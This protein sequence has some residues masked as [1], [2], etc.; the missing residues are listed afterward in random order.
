M[1]R[2]EHLS[3]RCKDAHSVIRRSIRGW[4][5]KRGLGQIGPGSELLHLRIAHAAGV[6]HHGQAIALQ[7]H[8]AKDVTLD[9]SAS[10]HGQTQL[11]LP[12]FSTTGLVLASVLM[13]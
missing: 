4:Q 13:G 11:D 1:S 8:R 12:V 6:N 2:K 7:W 9:K 5:L 10:F 3:G